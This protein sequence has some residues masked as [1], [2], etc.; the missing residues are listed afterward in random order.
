VSQI[1][2]GVVSEVKSKFPALF[3]QLESSEIL[4]RF[5]NG[6]KGNA[7]PIVRRAMHGHGMFLG[8]QLKLIDVG[9]KAHHSVVS[10]RDMVQA[11]SRH[12]MEGLLVGKPQG[13]KIGSANDMLCEFWAR[14]KLVYPS[15]P[16]HSKHAGREGKC[17]PIYFH[18]DEGR[19][20]KKTATMAM[21][22]HPCLGSGTR[23]KHNTDF[24]DMFMGL[25]YMS[26]TFKTRFIY[27][28]MPVGMY[29]DKPQVF[30]NL[31]KAMS[32]EGKDLF[33][34][35]VKLQN[36]DVIYLIVLGMK[37]DLPYLAKVGNLDRKFNR[38]AHP[39]RCVGLCHLC[40][41]GLLGYPYEDTGEEA[42]W[43]QSMAV[44]PK[45]WSSEPCLLVIPHAEPA[46]TFFKKDIF[47]TCHK[48][49]FCD[50]SSSALISTFD[51][52][53]FS[54][55]GSI[56]GKLKLA[57]DA[58]ATYCKDVCKTRPHMVHFTRDL[59]GFKD[60]ACYPVGS[61]FKGADTSL[62]CKWLESFYEQWLAGP[63]EAIKNRGLVEAIYK[64]LVGA[65]TFMHILY[66]SGLWLTRAEGIAA[67]T[68][69]RMFL[70]KYV[71]SAS[72]SLGLQRTRFA[73]KP[74]LH[75]FHHFCEAIRWQL[76]EL[77]LEF[78]LNPLV[79]GCQ[80]DED[81]VGKVSR[82]NRRVHVS[83][84]VERTLEKY[85]ANCYRAWLP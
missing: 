70:D 30:E 16:I 12:D 56:E 61:W 73:L 28:I 7:D 60:S 42:A 65:N 62:M 84:Q 1:A 79:E 72:L 23:A 39:S 63:P 68:A 75:C 46:C 2:D 57:Y 71:E 82:L 55:S 18:G 83:T 40:L 58:F 37:G 20:Q 26:N 76:V 50:L 13:Y 77:N 78:A 8:L 38:R 15:H 85:L 27:S 35:G 47:H 25:N 5:A 6:N 32:K 31:L 64:S 81:M 48:G 67:Y 45:P 33:E 24:D 44:A 52:G 9:L 69:G 36:G 49:I 43:V 66:S 34:I 80:C 54:A 17:I 19:G 22:W 29:R 3:P 53:C 11:M 14:H 59:V 10:I 21:Q 4:R 51:E 74:K 41:A